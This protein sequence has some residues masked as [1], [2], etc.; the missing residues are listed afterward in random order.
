MTRTEVFF[1]DLPI[2][3]ESD[4]RMHADELRALAARLGLA[5][6]R[7]ASG[8]RLVVTES[9]ESVAFGHYRFA[10]EASLLIGRQVCTF[11]SEV[12]S[13]AG[14]SPDLVASAPL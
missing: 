10:V 3:E 1:E 6:L 8:N 7:Y 11:W 4:I 13:N 2:A 5:E 9:D 12:L 14:V